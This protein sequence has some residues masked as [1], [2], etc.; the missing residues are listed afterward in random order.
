MCATADEPDLEIVIGINGIYTAANET[1]STGM[2]I[3]TWILLCP[4]MR[5]ET[6]AG[7]MRG[8]C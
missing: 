1:L 6:F 4:N 7:V 5:A 3:I 2:P 8:H